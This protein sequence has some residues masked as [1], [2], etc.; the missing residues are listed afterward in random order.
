[1]REHHRLGIRRH[2]RFPADRSGQPVGIDAEQH[3]VGAP[4][5][6]PVG[7]QMYLLRR[8]KMDETDVVEGVW[9]VLAAV[10]SQPPVV[11]CTDVHGGHLPTLPF[12]QLR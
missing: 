9:T 2:T 1:M 3:Q 10:L 12:P 7:R 8:G 4:G 5:V 6:E 11:R